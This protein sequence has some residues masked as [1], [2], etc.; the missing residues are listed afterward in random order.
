MFVE[1]V[2]GVVQPTVNSPGSQ[3]ARP[4]ADAIK[5]LQGKKG[6][7]VDQAIK[8]LSKDK[9]EVESIAKSMSKVADSFNHRLKFQVDDRSGTGIVVRVVDRQSGDVIKEFPPEEF[10][11]MVAKMKEFMGAIFDQ[12][13]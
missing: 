11:N 9:N 2:N 8:E 5:L 6:Q 1:G 10:L 3:A 7:N 4:E 13:V 12:K